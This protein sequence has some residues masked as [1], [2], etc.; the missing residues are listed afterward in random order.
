MDDDGKEALYVAS[1]QPGGHGLLPT[2]QPKP[3]GE[4][5]GIERPGQ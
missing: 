5:D 3:K 2:L 1:L 4:M